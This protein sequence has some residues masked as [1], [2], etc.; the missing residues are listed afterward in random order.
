[1]VVG[2]HDVS[3]V[4]CGPGELGERGGGWG[5]VDPATGRGAQAPTASLGA[6]PRSRFSDESGAGGGSPGADTAQSG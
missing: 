2:C 1:M 6:S 4:L 3:A 5:G